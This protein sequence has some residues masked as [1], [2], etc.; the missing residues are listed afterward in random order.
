MT[1]ATLEKARLMVEAGLVWPVG[2]REWAVQ[3][4]TQFHGSYLVQ[5]IGGRLTC[6]CKGYHYRGRCKHTL[7]VRLLLGEDA[8]GFEEEPE[9]GG[10]TQKVDPWSRL[11]Y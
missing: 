1:Q 11:R 6:E 9:E 8:W 5:D 2:E 4:M 3:S 10:G 7:A